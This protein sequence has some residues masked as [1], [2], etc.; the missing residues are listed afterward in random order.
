[1]KK[2]LNF[3][4]FRRRSDGEDADLALGGESSKGGT[5]AND[6]GGV[7]GV[8]KEEGTRTETQELDG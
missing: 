6:G 2:N 4:P 5:S 7:E 8:E 3:I 1:M